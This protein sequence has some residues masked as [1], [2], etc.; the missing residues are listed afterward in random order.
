M[1]LDHDPTGEICKCGKP[2][3]WHR[4]SRWRL[5]RR[6]HQAY[7]REHPKASPRFRIIGTDGEGQGRAEHIYNYLAAADENGQ[8]WDLGDN[9]N[10]QIST[11]DFLDFIL[12]LPVRTL[13]FAF[14][15]LYDLTKGLEQLDDTSLYLLFHEK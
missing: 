3:A 4:G 11:P 14:A 1:G 7:E 12:E 15:F 9:P 5:N 6:Y 13:I 8:T 2:G 10:R